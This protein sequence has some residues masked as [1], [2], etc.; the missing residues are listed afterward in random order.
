MSMKHM[1]KDK[2]VGLFLWQQSNYHNSYSKIPLPIG[3][4]A[5]RHYAF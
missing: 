5:V 3:Q 2:T 1:P 4:P